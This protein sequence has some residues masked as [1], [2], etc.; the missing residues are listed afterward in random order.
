MQRRMVVENETTRIIFFFLIWNFVFAYPTFDVNS[1]KQE[2]NVRT[3]KILWNFDFFITFD[4]NFVSSLYVVRSVVQTQLKIWLKSSKF[5]LLIG[6]DAAN[7]VAL[8][9]LA[10]ADRWA[11]WARRNE[12]GQNNNEFRQISKIFES[13]NYFQLHIFKPKWFHQ[14]LK[15]LKL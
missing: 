14:S 7:F 10:S 15:T 4:T 5:C 12:N 1:S 13:S 9:C 3:V 8:N 11:L 2:K 6:Y